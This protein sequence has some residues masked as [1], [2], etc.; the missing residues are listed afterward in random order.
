MKLSDKQNLVASGH[1]VGL[2]EAR[3]KTGVVA[4]PRVAN[5]VQ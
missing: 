1:L 5:S 3:I 2:I 4:V